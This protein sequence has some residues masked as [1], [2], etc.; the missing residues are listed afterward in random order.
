MNAISYPVYQIKSCLGGFPSMVP[1]V[2][3]HIMPRRISTAVCCDGYGLSLPPDPSQSGT[4]LPE[5][6]S[7]LPILYI[8]GFIRTIILPQNPVLTAKVL[9]IWFC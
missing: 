2:V 9:I 5:G 6:P 7:R 4:N 1:E 8:W 3:P